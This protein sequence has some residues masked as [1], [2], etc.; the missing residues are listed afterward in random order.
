MVYGGQNHFRYDAHTNSKH[1]VIK[2]NIKTTPS[3]LYEDWHNME[4]YFGL[5]ENTNTS[6]EE[7]VQT[8]NL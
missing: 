5:I 3:E 8:Y 2:I 6:Q 1:Q 4:D 7:R